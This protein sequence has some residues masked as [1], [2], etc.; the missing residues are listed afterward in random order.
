[1]AVCPYC[2]REMLGAT[3]CTVEV[4]HRNGKALSL[5]RYGEEIRF[6]RLARPVDPCHDC[7]VHPGALHHP[8]CDWA[9]CPACRGQMLSCGCRF[10]EDPPADDP[11]DDDPELWGRGWL[12]VPSPN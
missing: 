5:P 3:S 2:Q 8:G 7:G 10:D 9:Q 12:V 6:G 4:F 1:M 11:L